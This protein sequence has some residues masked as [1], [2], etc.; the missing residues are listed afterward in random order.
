[1]L[2]ELLEKHA[3]RQV[4]VSTS[5]FKSVSKLSLNFKGYS[6]NIQGPNLELLINK[7]KYIKSI[8]SYVNLEYIK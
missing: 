8:L 6:V 2:G 7:L 3:V 1:M 5:V 4:D